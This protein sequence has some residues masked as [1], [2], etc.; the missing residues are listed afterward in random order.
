MED[1]LDQ[2]YSVANVR[3]EELLPRWRASTD[4][5]TGLHASHHQ[6][7]SAAEQSIYPF[8]GRPV[9]GELNTLVYDPERRHAFLGEHAKTAHGRLNALARARQADK[10]G[11]PG[12]SAHWQRLAHAY[13]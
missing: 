7:A 10:L 6:S 1:I 4:E 12:L 11:K 9:D 5:K 13:K 3:S 8:T 2:R